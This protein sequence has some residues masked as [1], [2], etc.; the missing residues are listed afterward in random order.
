MDQI[1]W[2]NN[3]TSASLLYALS[4]AHL[5]IYEETFHMPFDEHFFIVELQYVP[6]VEDGVIGVIADSRHEVSI[7]RTFRR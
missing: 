4:D 7:C 3:C 1:R 5:I 2:I 6:N